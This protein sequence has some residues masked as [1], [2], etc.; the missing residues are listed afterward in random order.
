M[1]IAIGKQFLD[2][3]RQHT[4]FWCQ[5][6]T[7]EVPTQSSNEEHDRAQVIG[8]AWENLVALY[9]LQHGT[10]PSPIFPIERDWI[11]YQIAWFTRRTTCYFMC[12]RMELGT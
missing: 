8:D 4:L 6:L 12:G 2:G 9:K 10:F 11:S 5:G 3:M 7:Y 1:G